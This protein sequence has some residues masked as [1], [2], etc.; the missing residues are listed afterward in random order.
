VADNRTAIV[1]TARDEASGPLGKVGASIEKLSGSTAG[2]GALKTALGGLGAAFSA[3]ALISF[4]KS[5]IDAADNINDLSQKVGISIRDL[6]TWQLAAEQ[7]GTSLESVARGVKGL[8]KNMVENGDAFRAAGIT[9]TDANGAMVQ[10]ADIFA[11]MPD[12]IEKTTLAVELFGKAGMDMI[13]LLNQGSAGLADAQAKAAAYAEKLAELAPKADAFN[14]AMA[15]LGLVGKSVAIDAL[16]PMVEGLTGLAALLKDATSGADGLARALGYLAE[17]T[18]SELLGMA[19]QLANQAGRSGVKNAAP[20]VK[21]GWDLIDPKFGIGAATATSQQADKSA[22]EKDA[23]AKAEI[24]RKKRAGSASK[25]ADVFDPSDAAFEM[26]KEAQQEWDKLNKEK[27]RAA[28][29]NATLVEQ[30]RLMEDPLRKYFKQ[31]DESNNLEGI[32]AEEKDRFAASVIAKMVAEIAKLGELETATA[33]ANETANALG[34]TFASAFEDAI[35]EGKEFSEVLKGL[36]KDIERIIVRKTVTE[37]LGNA[38]SDLI[39]GSGINLGSLF[40]GGRA[41]GGPVS[42]GQFYVVGENGPEIL[43]PNSGGTVIPAGAGGGAQPVTVNL[44]YNIDSRTDQA[45]ILAV[46]MRTKQDTIAAIGN[47]QRRGG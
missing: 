10:L 4:A 44:T 30:Y 21:S 43:V 18:D 19:A 33:E 41:A 2:L 40:G 27:E 15:E 32:G 17:K 37:P 8:A 9:A 5:T 39:G 34:F 47:V 12:G 36:A 45:T 42:A 29:A 1:I 7:S 38:I 20:G 46:M 22:A 16:L 11:N 23:M 14:D 26:A 24:L 6:A 25:A 28:K 35:V 13:P 3:G 31:L